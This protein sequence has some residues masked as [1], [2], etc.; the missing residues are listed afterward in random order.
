MSEFQNTTTWTYDNRD[1]I[2]VKGASC[3]AEA[4]NDATTFL[5]RETSGDPSSDYV[6]ASDLEGDDDESGNDTYVFRVKC[7]DK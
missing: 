4:Y 6:I 1:S 5:D 7:Y 3:Y 2:T